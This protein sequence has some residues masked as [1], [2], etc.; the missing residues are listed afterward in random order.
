LRLEAVRQLREA[1]ISV[2]IFAM[3]ILPG[4]TD[5]EEDLDA[6][7]RAAR[8]A[9]A[10]WFG[11]NVLFLM[12]ASRKTFFPFIDQKFPKL[13]RRYHQWYDGG[14]YAPEKYRAEIQELVRKLRQKY[15]LGSRYEPEGMK[16]WSSPQMALD[17]T[18]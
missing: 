12:P 16:P 2:G 9:G 5:R 3:P 4:L 10:Q 7:A 6:L 8:D 17:L 15:K 13:A 1:G 11:G 14:G 18:A